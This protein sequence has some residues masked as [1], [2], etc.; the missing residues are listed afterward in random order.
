[1][2]TKFVNTSN[3]LKFNQAL[4]ELK[5]RGASEACIVVVDGLPGLGKTTSL[6][7]FAAREQAIYLR[8]KKEYKP[9][10]F[11][12]ELLSEL[13]QDAPHAFQKKFNLALRSLMQRQQ[14]AIAAGKNFALIIDEADHVSTNSAIME[15]VR[16]LSDMTELPMILVGMGKIRSNLA[17]FP[18]IA[19]R[20]SK[21]VNFEPAKLEDVR[22]FFNEKCEIPVADD[23]AGFVHKV[24]N[25]YNREIIE[26]M[27]IIERFGMRSPPASPLGLT[28]AEMAGQ[29]IVNDRETGQPISVPE[30]VGV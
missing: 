13:R 16:D 26:A 15:T 21:Y 18:Q 9:S 12:N 11:L 28:L 14:A 5:K 24:T 17:R 8:A 6:S 4:S 2:K 23:L 19:S 30:L 7:R 25:G 29:H 22:L 20:V 1:M 10:W 3:V 27:A